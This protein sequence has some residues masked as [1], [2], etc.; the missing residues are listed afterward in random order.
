MRIKT[1][2]EALGD[3]LVRKADGSLSADPAIEL[4]DELYGPIQ[5]KVKD[6]FIEILRD[7]EKGID[8]RE[9]VFRLLAEIEAER[10]DEGK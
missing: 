5:S 2:A 10:K 4:I 6:L 3:L 7:L 8:D 1:S 9:K